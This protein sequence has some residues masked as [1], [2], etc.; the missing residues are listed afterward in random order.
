M[1]PTVATWEAILMDAKVD[2]V[3]AEDSGLDM[4]EDMEDTGLLDTEE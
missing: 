2:L 4:E 3:D 1:I